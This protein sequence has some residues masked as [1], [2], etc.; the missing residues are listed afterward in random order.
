MARNRPTARNDAKKPIR[1]ASRYGCGNLKMSEVAIIAAT[2]QASLIEGVLREK[3]S[4]RC[5]CIVDLRTDFT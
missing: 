1:E 3:F 2:I 4:P 5:G